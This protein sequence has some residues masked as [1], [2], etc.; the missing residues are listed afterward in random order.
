MF[1]I[2]FPMNRWPKPVYKRSDNCADHFATVWS[3]PDH[4]QRIFQLFP[5]GWWFASHQ[6]AGW[7]FANSQLAGWWFASSQPAA[8]WFAN[9][10][11]A[12]GGLQAANQLVRGLQ[13]T[14]QLVGGLQTTNPLVGGLQTTN[15]LVGGLQTAS[16]LVGDLQN[17]KQLVG[18][19]QTTNLLVGGLQTANQLGK[20]GKWVGSV[21]GSSGLVQNDQR[22]CRNVFKRVFVKDS[23]KKQWKDICCYFLAVWGPV[24]GSFV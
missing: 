12:L 11:P 3:S 8:W 9:S 17:T 19:L 2:V 15:Q 16:Q 23:L 10:R 18:G 14:N 20:V 7:W 6:P 22:N 21:R 5:A 24:L 4:S 1:F 13:T